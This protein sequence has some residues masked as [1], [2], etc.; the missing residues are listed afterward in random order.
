MASGFN[1]TIDILADS[2]SC[3][4]LKVPAAWNKE[5]LAAKLLIKL[6]L[7]DP[8]LNSLNM[9]ALFDI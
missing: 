1:S 8:N 2:Q 4:T 9:K 7:H 3:V 6:H 5:Y